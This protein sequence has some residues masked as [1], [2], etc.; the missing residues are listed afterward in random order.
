MNRLTLFLVAVILVL[1]VFGWGF[2]SALSLDA[3]SKEAYNPSSLIRLHVRPHS[4]LQEEQELK[5]L[6]K[7][8]VLEETSDIMVDLSSRREAEEILRSNLHRIRERV[9]EVLQRQGFNHQVEVE[10]KE[11]FAPT[12]H[13]GDQKLKAGIYPSLEVSIGEGAGDNWWCVIFPPL[14]FVES[15]EEKALLDE[16]EEDYSGLVYLQG[17]KEV[18]LEFRFRFFEKYPFMAETLT[19]AFER[20]KDYTLPGSRA[21]AL[22][23][24]QD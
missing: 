23:E 15:L 21:R 7:D 2:T 24:D 12:R 6:V 8:R 5:L 14:C 11:S 17:E 19:F 10:I 9:L 13:Y 18:P 20:I 4:N 22:F 16:E 3:G 1:V